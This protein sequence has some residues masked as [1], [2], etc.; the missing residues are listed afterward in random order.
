MTNAD[1]VAFASSPTSPTVKDYWSTG[2]TMPTLD[3]KNDYTFTTN[4]NTT[5]VTFIAKRLLDTNDP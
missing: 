3:S 1:M 4:I 5:H 2:H